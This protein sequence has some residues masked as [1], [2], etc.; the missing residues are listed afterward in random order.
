MNP[1]QPISPAPAVSMLPVASLEPH[2]LLERLT[3]LDV[4]EARLQAR[5]KKDGRH[6]AEAL[7]AAGEARAA[8]AA[9]K[10]S[11]AG[12]GILE[13]L[14]GVPGP[15]GGVLIVDGRHRLQAA[16]EAGIQRVPVILH[17]EAEALD[18]ISGSV[19]A[20]RHLS[21]SALA[22]IAVLTHPAVATEGAERQTSMLNRGTDSPSR[23]E[24]ATGEKGSETGTMAALAARYGVSLRLVV[25]ACELYR[26]G[27]DWPKLIGEAEVTLWAGGGLGA[28]LAGLK[29]RIDGEVREKP[30]SAKRVLEAIGYAYKTQMGMQELWKRWEI[31]DEEKRGMVAVQIGK[32]MALAPREVRDAVTAALAAIREEEAP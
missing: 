1:D 20:R 11:V 13:P 2:P 5:A 29:A 28:V 10:S 32:K 23:T 26:L 12:R 8:W 17:P 19:C 25:Q 4:L 22:Y 16:R 9:L 18:I 3:M 27:L 14:L 30:R 15:M 21:K 31:I 6:R 7:E 24:C